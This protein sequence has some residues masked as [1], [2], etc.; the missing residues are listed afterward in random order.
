KPK[1]M[2]PRS[3]ADLGIDARN[4]APPRRPGEERQRPPARRTV[5]AALLRPAGSVA[6]ATPGP[7]LRPAL[8]LRPGVRGAGQEVERHM[9]TVCTTRG[10]GAGRPRLVHDRPAARQ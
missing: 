3:A 7:R 6:R 9:A 8:W 5:A 10:A 4:P 2:C 1:L